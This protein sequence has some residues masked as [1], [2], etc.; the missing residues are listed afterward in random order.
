MLTAADPEAYASLSSEDKRLVL[1]LLLSLCRMPD[2]ERA[3]VIAGL[4]EDIVRLLSVCGPVLNRYIPHSPDGN[5]KQWVFLSQVVS[6][7]REVFYGGAAGGA[8]SDSLLA[9]ALQYVEIPG[10]AA[11]I[12]RRT[13]QDLSLPGALL[14]RAKSWLSGTD[15]SW[16]D[17]LKRWTFP[18]GA[19]LVFGYLEHAG[20]E[21]RYQSAEFQYIGWDEGSQ[22]PEKQ[23]DYVNARCRRPAPDKPNARQLASVPLRIRIGSNPGGVGHHYLKQRYIDPDRKGTLP[24]GTA[25]IRSTL[26]DNPYIDRPSYEA[27]LAAIADPTDRK[28]LRDGDWDVLPS[29][30]LIQR[31]WLRYLEHAPAALLPGA[32]DRDGARIARIWDL[33]GTVPSPGN[34]NPDYTAGPLVAVYEGKVYLLDCPLERITPGQV[35]ALV[36]GTAA[37]DGKAIPIHLEQEPGQSGKAQVAHYKLLLPGYNVSG[38]VASGSKS[39]RLG[40]LASAAEAGNFIIVTDY[41]QTGQP[42]RW[43]P[44]LVEQITL[45]PSPG[46]KDD[47]PD[48]IARALEYLTPSQTTKQKRPVPLGMT[49]VAGADMGREDAP[50]LE[51]TQIEYER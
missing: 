36:K 50:V 15:A 48:A 25:V 37:L 13:Y 47:G 33:A 10:Y 11:I 41:Y 27:M 5:F 14:D 40:P 1:S 17:K 31:S 46:V 29:G 18:S 43:L 19:V 9:G 26:E 51:A 4:D 30:G 44:T 12:L 6:E 38:S 3:T 28:R 34:R 42:P 45:F 2:D 24:E 8:K 35:E 39:V 21:E 16:N 7:V 22:I 49:S 23:I 32:T 20:D